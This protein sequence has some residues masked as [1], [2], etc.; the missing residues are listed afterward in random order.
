MVVCSEGEKDVTPGEGGGFGGSP[1]GGATGYLWGQRCCKTSHN[2][3]DSPTT[4]HY[5]SK[6]ANSAKLHMRTCAR[7]QAHAPA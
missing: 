7:T 6:D 3:Q 5:P 1:C 4:M 2:A